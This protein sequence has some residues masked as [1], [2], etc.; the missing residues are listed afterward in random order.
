M[1]TLA[2][3][4]HWVLE[5]IERVESLSEGLYNRR[6]R[7]HSC[8]PLRRA[9]D[10]NSTFGDVMLHRHRLARLQERTHPGLQFLVGKDGTRTLVQIVCP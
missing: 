7:P 6:H 2:R 5:A 4:T 1:T 8:R 10:A 9:Q 3:T